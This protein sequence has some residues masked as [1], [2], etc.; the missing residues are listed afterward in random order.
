M[1]EN[2]QQLMGLRRGVWVLK[3]M[4]RFPK[5]CTFGQLQKQM[6]GLP[7]PTLSR[8]LKVM[9]DERLLEKDPTTGV[10]KAGVLAFNLS[11]RFLGR[12]SVPEVLQPI[13]DELAERCGESAAY[14]EYENRAMIFLATT[15]MPGS[16][17]YMETGVP[18]PRIAYH[19]FGQVCLAHMDRKKVEFVLKDSPVPLPLEKKAY[20]KR[21]ERIRQEGYFIEVGESQSVCTRITAPVFRG[22]GKFIGVLGITVLKNK[23]TANEKDGFTKHVKDAAEAASRALSRE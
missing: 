15:D 17:H 10:Y 18:N 22:S 12:A 14:C 3:I 9:V 20:Y 1:A 5:G 21:L 19:G 7:A 6:E 23:L 13:I 4:A 8:L 16:F 11:K 2:G